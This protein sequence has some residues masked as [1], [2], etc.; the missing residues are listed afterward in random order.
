M[1]AAVSVYT[2]T[3]LPI[4]VRV[5]FRTTFDLVADDPD[6]TGLDGR[7]FFDERA[8]DV[9][10]F[11]FR[12]IAG[13][14]RGAEAREPH[15]TRRGEHSVADAIRSLLECIQHDFASP[16]SRGSSRKHGQT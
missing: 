9:G 1:P 13:H 11:F 15:L 4:A 7:S 2:R 10:R 12:P 5:R 6:C 16:K 14:D 3:T 8:K